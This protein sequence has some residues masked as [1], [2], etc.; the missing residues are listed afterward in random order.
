MWKYFERCLG[1]DL[2][3]CGK[4]NICGEMISADNEKHKTKM[5]ISHHRK[6]AKPHGITDQNQVRNFNSLYHRRK[7]VRYVI[8]SDLPLS[9]IESVSYLDY[10]GYFVPNE[11]MVSRHTIRRDIL[12]YFGRR[13]KKL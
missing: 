10:I 12:K 7:F 9:H 8:G 5:L 4:C 3:K 1:P 11:H 2:Q 6:C 13:K